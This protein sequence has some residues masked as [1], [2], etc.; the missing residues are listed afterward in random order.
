MPHAVFR[1]LQLGSVRPEGWL[2]AELT[3]QCN[4]IT[5]H[6]SDFYFPFDRRRQ[7]QSGARQAYSSGAAG[8]YTPAAHCVP[9]ARSPSSRR[10]AEQKPLS[11]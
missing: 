5:G 3:K 6:Q 1:E 8:Q 10:S 11:S 7:K 2:H 4:G 9:N